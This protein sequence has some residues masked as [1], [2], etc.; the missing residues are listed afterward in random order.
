MEEREETKVYSVLEINQ[1]LRLLL[2][3]HFSASFWVW[4]EIQDLKIAAWRR[5]IYFSLV[6][7]HPQADEVVARIRAV[8]YSNVREKINYT[9]ERESI[10]IESATSSSLET[11]LQE[12]RE[13]KVLCR[14]NV[15]PRSGNYYLEIY[16][17]DPAYTLGKITQRRQE[18][19]E[20]LRKRGILD[21]NKALSFSL[22]PLDIGLITA[23]NSAAF[24]DFISEV[25]SFKFA[26]RIFVYDAHMQG[27]LTEKEVTEGIKF[28]SD[29]FPFL[30]A[31]VITR[32]GGSLADLGW[33]DSQKIALAIA[34]SK[35]P[36]LS[37]L[38]HQINLT[39]TDVASWSYFKT[40]TKVAQFLGERVRG[41]LQNIEE[42]EEEIIKQSQRIYQE[43]RMKLEV[44]FSRIASL[45]ERYLSKEKKDLVIAEISLRSRG[46][47]I[48][49][50]WKTNID[51]FLTNIIAEARRAL[52]KEALRLDNYRKRIDILRPQEVLRRGFSL[53]LVKN[54]PIRKIEELR[55][56]ESV[57]TILFQGR[58][59]SLVTR[60][61]KERDEEG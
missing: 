7:K 41:F 19:L 20:E 25:Q 13:I 50:L 45:T 46:L 5:N 48:L 44:K 60:I 16:A 58:F 23:Y 17:L 36:V 32:G 43:A 12:G 53:T 49:N 30:D 54:R 10:K 38:G 34:A 51:H 27:S 22:V 2:R 56:G 9:L 8:I 24:F 15:Y 14:L 26:F 52:Q 55:E 42:K 40:P 6:Q 31:I 21:R 18:L 3:E 61:S 1:Q 11:F 39:I 59:N 28:F 47:N 29:S 35:I 37:A 33:F 4:G 57:E